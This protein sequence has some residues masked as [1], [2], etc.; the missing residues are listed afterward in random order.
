VR[1]GN[2]DL[3]DALLVSDLLGLTVEVDSRDTRLVIEDL[4]LLHG[5]GGTFRLGSKG[6]EHGL[7]SD[8]TSGERGGRRGLVLAVGDLSVGEVPGDEGGVV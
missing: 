4:D 5:S 7:L 3:L 6:L 2:D 8:P 1:E